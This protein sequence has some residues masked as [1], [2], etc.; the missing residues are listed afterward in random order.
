MSAPYS[1]DY[2]KKDLAR[3]GLA[4]GD[5]CVVRSALREIGDVD[6]KR[7]AVV[8]DALL[9]TVGETG[10]VMTLAFT[11]VFKL[12]LDPDNPEHTFTRDT[13]PY[14]G[15]LPKECLS[16]PDSLR[17]RHPTS[18]FCAMG[19]DAHFL[20]D[21]HD[22]D[23]SC[24]AP[25]GKAVEKEGKMLIIGAL[26]AVPGFTS[27][28]WA[29]WVLGYANMSADKRKR[30]VYYI[31]ESGKKRLFVQRDV[32]GCSRGFGKFYPHYRKA[33]ILSEGK[34]GDAPS[35]LV[36]LDRAL[37]VELGLMKDNPR[38]PLC[39]DPCCKSCR[40]GWEFS[41]TPRFVFYARVKLGKALNRR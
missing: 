2:I 28:H 19:R 1:K 37:D 5:V 23:S 20:L 18:S 4:Q 39:D 33:G 10:T 41:D 34:I 15:G 9:E 17:S 14:S 3:L 27:A 26:D 38:V 22:E 13:E 32:G 16:R 8:L 7:S 36:R 11:K 35:M 40:I 31:D 30:G 12:P 21:G 25:I 6:G 29:Q 24:Y